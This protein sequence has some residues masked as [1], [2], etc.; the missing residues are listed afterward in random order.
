[1]IVVDDGSPKSPAQP[2]DRRWAASDIDDPPHAVGQARRRLGLAHFDLL[3]MDVDVRWNQDA[4]RNLA[5]SQAP[6]K[7]VLL[8][9]MDHLVPTA[10]WRRLITGRLSWKQAYT[11]ARKSGSKLTDR[12]PHANSW[13]LTVE[14]FDQM[15]GYDERFA[16]YYGTDGD[17]KRRLQK[18]CKIT[19][20]PE[21]LHEVTPETVAD[22]NTRDYERK[23]AEDRANIPRIIAERGQGKP[24]RG[25]FPWHRVT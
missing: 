24:L 13:L 25:R 3:R 1:L 23:T 5:V 11:F 10:T 4:C 8:T 17:F 6:T 14:T 21:F 12:N 9:D 22:C 19:A 18:V 15:G 16:G 2:P 7:W 20:L